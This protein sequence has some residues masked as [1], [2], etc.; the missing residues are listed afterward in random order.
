MYY[1]KPILISPSCPSGEDD[2]LIQSIGDYPIAVN[3]Y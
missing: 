1:A 2:S 3:K